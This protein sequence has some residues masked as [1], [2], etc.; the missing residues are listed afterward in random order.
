M[1]HV[2]LRDALLCYVA[3]RVEGLVLFNFNTLSIGKR[4]VSALN[5]ELSMYDACISMFYSLKKM[6]FASGLKMSINLSITRTNNNSITTT[7][8]QTLAKT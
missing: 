6:I 5:H 2:I 7:L 8:L 3:K 1:G 4:E